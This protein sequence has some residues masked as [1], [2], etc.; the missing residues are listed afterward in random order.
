MY[1]KIRAILF[2]LSIAVFFVS[3][4]LSLIFSLGYDISWINLK[5]SKAGL[6]D[7]NTRPEG[8]QVYLNNRYTN[9][10]TPAVLRELKPG[11]YDLKLQLEDHYPWQNTVLV[12]AGRVTELKEII[13]FKRLPYLE[14]INVEE[15]ADF[16][17]SKSHANVFLLSKE[18]NRVYKIDIKGKSSQA[19][20][21]LPFHPE[22]IKKW[23]VSPDEKKILYT[24]GNKVYV[25]FLSAEPNAILPRDFMI[26]VLEET[27]DIFWHVDNEHIIV[28]TVKEIKIFE[29]LSQGR[30]NTITL[31]TLNFKRPKV[32]YDTENNCLYFTDLQETSI[33]RYSNLY[34]IQLG[35]R[36]IFPSIEELEKK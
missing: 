8:A 12:Q 16:A 18:D 25:G 31:A 36:Q 30:N 3:V 33:G 34:R 6:I 35:R 29:L 5:V 11:I 2:Y 9:Q 24:S 20:Y 32:F 26:S 7:V 15:V 17:L 21:K 23:L 4:P 1:Q 10:D 13:L 22:R 19:V 14:K 27:A 28:I